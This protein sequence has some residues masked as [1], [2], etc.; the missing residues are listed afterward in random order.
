MWVNFRC[1][2]LI[3]VLFSRRAHLR[4]LQPF[5]TNPLLL[6]LLDRRREN[7]LDVLV[8][9]VVRID[10]VDDL[11]LGSFV[12]DLYR[13]LRRRKSRTCS[14]GFVVSVFVSRRPRLSSSDSREVESVSE[15]VRIESGWE[16]L[17]EEEV[18]R[19]IERSAAEGTRGKA[20]KKHHWEGKRRERKGRG[21]RTASSLASK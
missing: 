12:V 9:C 8:V 16:G 15:L 14:S 10:D 2:S 7:R 5:G 11:V 21:E 1:S 19:E 18:K 13:L 6:L 20:G 3:G 17:R 4:L